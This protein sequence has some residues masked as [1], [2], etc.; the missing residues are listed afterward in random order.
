M[1]STSEKLKSVAI[2]AVDCE[3]QLLLATLTDVPVEL[4]I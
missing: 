4:A 3:S 1:I 2:R